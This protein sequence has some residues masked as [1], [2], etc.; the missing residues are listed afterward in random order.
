MRVRRCAADKGRVAG[1]VRSGGIDS[2][3]L[4]RATQPSGAW[5][6][7]VLIDAQAS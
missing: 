4:L 1:G 5:F 2:A 3:A 7:T 6:K